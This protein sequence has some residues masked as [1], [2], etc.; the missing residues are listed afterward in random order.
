LL[1]RFPDGIWLVELAALT[2]PALV[3]QVVATVLGQREEP[4]RSLL[5]TL[6]GYLG[7]RQLLLVL[8]NGEHLIGAC[9]ELAAGLLRTCPSMRLLATSREGLEVAGETLYR[10]PSLAVPDPQLLPAV[11][12]L[13]D[14]E[15]VRLF[16]D[17]ARTRRPQFGLTEANAAAVAA[18]CR[19]LDGIPL[20]IELAAARV[21]VLSVEQIAARLDDRFRLLTGGPRTALPRQQTLRAA[22]DWSWDLLS[23]GE[24]V[25]LRR[26]AAFQRGC[27]L[28]AAEAICADGSL[29]SAEVLDLLA[30]LVSTP[31]DQTR[32]WLLE[33]VR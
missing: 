9:A 30:G 33:T 20:A 21:D 12:R 31:D 29:P 18:V 8:D 6:A 17:R 10:V 5:A 26:L 28:D 14:Y 24:R 27:T 3:P 2:D 7:P 23:A 16:L 4:V 15:A 11:G 25:L 13:P 1:D 19:R 32:C 22:M